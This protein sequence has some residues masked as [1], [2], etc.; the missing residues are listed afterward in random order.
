MEQI[1]IY[2][3][4]K[5]I[6]R[7]VAAESLRDL[8]SCLEPYRSIY[9]VI[10]GNVAQKCPAT[11]Q[12]TEILKNR[13]AKIKLIET[14]EEGKTL[15]TVMDICAW[16]LENGADRDA[17]ILAVGGGIT[18]DMVGF[19]SCI[20]KRGVRFA[21]VPTTL[22]SQVDAAIG[23]KTGVN[24]DKYKNILGIIRQP[25]FT[26]MCPQLL[27][28]LPQRDFL[29]GV[30]EML[31][32]FIIEDNGNYQKAA[33]LFFDISSEYHVE[34][35]MYGKDEKQ[36]WAEILKKHRR[37]LSELISAAARVKAGVVS[38]DQFE[39]DERRKLNLG[40]TFAHAI[41]TLAQREYA[42][43]D[44]AQQR[45]PEGVTHGEAVAMGMVLAAKLADRYYRN[46]RND[47]TELE[48]KISNDLWDCN[49]PCYCPYSIEEM[50]QIMKKD[51]KAEG[52]KV[53]FVL[54]KAIG[55]VE[56]VALTVDEV[57]RLMK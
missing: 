39:K 11:G 13:N 49:I 35:M 36:A 9:A 31:K 46:D 16:L 28:S 18:T 48:A 25:A 29:S 2:S 33:D 56:V 40:H 8:T 52:G 55:E 26:Y 10:D 6:S 57:C 27:E 5:A 37:T 32:T 50:A 34:V 7:I 20:Y 45:L 4:K 41:E 1:N 3:G 47:P 53:H 22:L 24:F 23:G 51:K 19:A 38:R 30:A 15:E 12:L 54:P 14:S 42:E 17:M 21:Y 43:Q 44:D